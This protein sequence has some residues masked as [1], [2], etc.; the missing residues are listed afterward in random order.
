M[1]ILILFVFVSSISFGQID[2]LNMSCIDSS[3]AI[4]FKG[5]QN[6]LVVIGIDFD[7]ILLM[8]ISG[9]T[10]RKYPQNRTFIYSPRKGE[11]DTILVFHEGVEVFRKDFENEKIGNF[12]VRLGELKDSLVNKEDLLRNLY[13]NLSMENLNYKLRCSIRRFR[14]RIHERDGTEITSENMVETSQYWNEY[15]EDEFYPNG[16]RF[17]PNQIQKISLMNPG[18]ILYI[19]KGYISC[20]S[21]LIK[22]INP[23]LKFTIK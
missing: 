5:C 23:N 16:S 21:G 9:D 4:L 17:S 3:K 2:I 12:I 8:N 22:G 20:S 13:L 19:E 7:S 6:K 1:R 10:L 11:N 18:D 15:D 14:I